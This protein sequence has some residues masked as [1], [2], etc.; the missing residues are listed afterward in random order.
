MSTIEREK[1]QTIEWLPVEKPLKS[2]VD[3]IRAVRKEGT[4]R[5][6]CGE[7]HI[8]VYNEPGFLQA[9]TYAKTTQKAKLWVITG[10]I[11][12]IDEDGQ[13]GVLLL[14]KRG[15]IDKLYHRAARGST[16]H[17]RL[18]E[19]EDMP[20]YYAEFP[21]PPLLPVE[22]RRRVNTAKLFPS[23]LERLVEGDRVSFDSWLE[24]LES[25]QETSSMNSLPLVTDP[26]SF[27]G[28]LELAR[29]KNLVFKYLGPHALLAL[30]G[31]KDIL[32]P[33]KALRV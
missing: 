21:H 20:R 31:A 8:A 1:T 17:F 7:A 11:M 30:P 27:R 23:R 32:R 22:D 26:E 33:Y 9:A 25:M 19:T 16:P 29:Q 3:D 12:L 6:F 10:P 28:L 24:R 15:I 5:I 14:K 4:I 2:L 13:N 18:V